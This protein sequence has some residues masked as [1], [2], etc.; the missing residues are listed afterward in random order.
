VHPGAAEVCNGVDDNCSATVDEGGNA[1]CDDTNACTTDVCGGS[2]G[3]AHPI[4]DLDGD[5]HP[6][7]ACGGNDCLDSNASVWLAPAAV[8]NL[9]VSTASPSNPSWDSQAGASGP[10]TLYDLV[11]GTVG[12]PAGALNFTLASCLQSSSST[13]YSD[14]HSGPPSGAAFWYLARGRNACATGTYG[15]AARDS[16]IPSCP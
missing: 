15:S 5:A 4:R 8:T 6:D 10:G 7:A 1:L 14:S 9:V 16:G 2:L 13:S 3:C 11:S 12:P